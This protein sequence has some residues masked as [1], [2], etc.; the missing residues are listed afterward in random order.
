MAHPNILAA[1]AALNQL[2]QSWAWLADHIEPGHATPT[3]RTMGVAARI[4]RDKQIRAERKD[5]VTQLRAGLSP[6][7]ASP[8]PLV[9]STLDAQ[10]LALA[11]VMDAAW[12]VTSALRTRGPMLAYSPAVGSD[13]DRF[14]GAAAYLKVTLRLVT[15]ELAGTIGTDLDTADRLAR[16]VTGCGPDQRR[17][18]GECPACGRRGLDAEVSAAD[19]RDWTVECSRRDCLCRGVDCMCRRPVRYPGARHRWAFGEFGQLDRL[20]DK[21]AA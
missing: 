5:L 3:R 2:R 21:V 6:A 19:R 17:L 9:V 11:A 12:L 14:D 15:P 8:A 16:A 20:L 10:V 1:T 7:G 18:N 4:Q 13:D